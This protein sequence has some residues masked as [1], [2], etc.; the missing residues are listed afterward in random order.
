MNHTEDPLRE[1]PLFE[2][3]YAPISAGMQAL[4]NGPLVHRNHAEAAY[5]LAEEYA[6]LGF[7]TLDPASVPEAPASQAAAEPR[8]AEAAP[9][10]AAPAAPAP[11]P[12]VRSR[13]RCC[14]R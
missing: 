5:Q 2:E 7:T 4:Q 3:L 14:R 10:K 13:R 1:N 12:Q 11:T 6:D 9:T 8:P